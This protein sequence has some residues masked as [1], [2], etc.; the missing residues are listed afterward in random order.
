MS[1]AWR[2]IGWLGIV[3]FILAPAMRADEP[4]VEPGVQHVVVYHAAGRYG[5]WPANH[6]IW[7]WGNEILVGFSRGYH[8]D[9]GPTSHAIDR[10]R[11]EEHVLGRS[12]DGGLTWTVEEPGRQ[13]MLL[14]P[15]KKLH[16]DLLPEIRRPDW[17]D[18]PGGINF[19]H[20]DFAMT[21][22]MDDIHVGPSCFYHS[23]DRGRTWHGPF[24]FPNLG[25]AGISA[26]TDYIVVDAK[27][28]LVILTAAKSNGKEGRPLCARTADGGKSW[29]MVSWIAPEQTGYA[30]MPSTVRLSGQGLLTTIRYREPNNGKSWIDGYYSSDNGQSW[31]SRNRP[32]PDTGEGNPP[33]LI[34]LQDGR[35]C[36]TWGQRK[37]PFGIRAK[38]SG[39]EGRTWS[40]DYV[41]RADGKSRDVGYP[42]TVQRPDGKLVV[43]YYFCADHAQE[44]D[45]LATLWTP[46]QRSKK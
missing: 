42:R 19:L 32:V 26:R 43:V 28:C 20:P 39:D 12:L 21:L 2:M 45:I 36:L 31:S 6:G 7:N 3:G 9:G 22:R 24:R 44:R 10:D 34:R 35:L 4:A 38:L 16:D 33:S 18:C 8:K 30:I 46:P 17:T 11:P 41:L 15:K 27:T 25:T 1:R 37:S 14:P 29:E 40:D 5:G 13:G 23:D